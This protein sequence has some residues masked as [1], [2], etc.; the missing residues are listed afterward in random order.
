MSIP[1]FKFQILDFSSL[2]LKFQIAIV[3]GIPDSRGQDF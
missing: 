1:D 2:E 3:R